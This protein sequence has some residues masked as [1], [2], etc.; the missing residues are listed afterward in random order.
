MDRIDIQAMEKIYRINIVYS[1]VLIS[2]G[3][4]GFL[5]RYINQGDWQFTSLIPVAF[6]LVMIALT[7]GIKRH[8]RS[9]SHLAVALTFILTVMVAVMLFI[10][11]ADGTGMNRKILV[12]LIILAGSLMT[13]GYSVASFISA[14]RKNDS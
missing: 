5:S 9:I 10:N 13:L 4:F 14:R 8:N 2:T 1:L 12:F 3:I 6:G 11:L 7:G